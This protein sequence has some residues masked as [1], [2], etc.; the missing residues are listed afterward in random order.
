MLAAPCAYGK[1]TLASFMIDKAQSK[2]KRSIFIVDRS[3][4][5]E[6]AVERF[7]DDGLE[8][9]VIQGAHEK[10]NYNK[11]VQVAT[12]QTLLRRGQHPFDFAFIDECHVLYEEHK[13]YMA[14]Y[15]KVPFI[16]LSATPFAKGMGLHF[17]DLI[18]PITMEELIQ[19]GFLVDYDIYGPSKVDLT[20]IKTIR[21]EFDEK[22]L[23]KRVA[24]LIGDIYT[25]HREK[26]AGTPTVCFAVNRAHSQAIAEKFR[27]KGVSA[28]HVDHF[29]PWD[30]RQL[31][32]EEQ[33]KGNIE[34]I[35]S[36]GIYEKGWDSPITQTMIDAGPTKSLMRH[37][38]R[39]G[40]VIR[41]DPK[42]PKKRALIL[43]H[44]G[45]AERLGFIEH[46][47][48]VRLCT[49][50]KRSKQEDQVQE[51]EKKVT[52]CAKCFTLKET[53]ICPACGYKK[54]YSQDIETVDAELEKKQK[55]HKLTDAQMKEYYGMLMHHARKK[56]YSDGWAYHKVREWAGKPLRSTKDVEIQPPND[57]VKKRIQYINIKAARGRK[58][59]ETAAT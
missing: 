29:T 12:I 44:A 36:V 5:V 20:G 46:L 17:D 53:A 56:G 48:P 16:G 35:S 11:P 21:G 9:G 31:I 19:Q 7:E 55:K 34:I 3:E 41:T 26:A 8:V 52:R 39:G 10:T 23:V 18:V 49:K 15:N 6:Q 28:A 54:E 47:I 43:D 58:K 57:I 42:N 13:R 40:R 1:T 22:E 32:N 4:L 37:G 51:R 14:E 50:V 25:H 59:N 24:H 30:Q 45:N 38:Q 27:A 33:K 2:D